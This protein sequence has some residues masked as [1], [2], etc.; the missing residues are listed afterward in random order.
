[1]GRNSLCKLQSGRRLSGFPFRGR[2]KRDNCF[3]SG[4]EPRITMLVYPQL[5]TGALG[6][7][8]IQKRRQLR[9]VV[10]RAADGTSLKLADPNAEFTQWD[11]RYTNLSDAEIAELQ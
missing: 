2:A 7:F 5:R 4:G 9:T 8:P 10:N 11:L 6:Q 1:M 3:D